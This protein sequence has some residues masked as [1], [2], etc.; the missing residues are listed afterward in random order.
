MSYN[1]AKQ[2]PEVFDYSASDMVYLFGSLEHPLLVC[3]FSVVT[4]VLGEDHTTHT[5]SALETHPFP[6]EGLGPSNPSVL[7]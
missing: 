6:R 7:T 2:E 4:F 1:L 5:K 3:D